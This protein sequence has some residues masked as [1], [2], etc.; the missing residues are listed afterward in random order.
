LGLGLSCTGC[1]LLARP[2]LTLTLAGKLQ[3]RLGQY[4]SENVRMIGP[5]DEADKMAYFAA[6]QY[7]GFRLHYRLGCRVRCGGATRGVVSLAA[8]SLRA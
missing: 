2:P 8:A 7:R 3:D 6:L 4:V 5:Y 1:H